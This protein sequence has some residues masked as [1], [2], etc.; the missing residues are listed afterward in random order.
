MYLQLTFK[1][2]GHSWT[3]TI[4][5]QCAMFWIS[6]GIY[7]PRKAI[8]FSLCEAYWYYCSLFACRVNLHHQ[9]IS[10]TLSFVLTQPVYIQFF[11]SASPSLLD[12]K[13]LSKGDIFSQSIF[14]LQ[15]NI[16]WASGIFPALTRDL[17]PQGFHN[18]SCFTRKLEKI[19]KK[20]R[21]CPNGHAFWSIYQNDCCWRLFHFHT[22]I[23]LFTHKG[24]M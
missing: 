24:K 11:C 14:Y 22:L 10:L 12:A 20:S 16:Q 4:S 13:L 8:F 7:D 18:M 15:S 9:K 2:E 3:K 19:K 6:V 23:N 5:R 17:H 21:S 1:S